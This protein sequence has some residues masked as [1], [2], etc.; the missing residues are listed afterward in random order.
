M[1]PASASRIDIYSKLKIEGFLWLSIVIFGFLGALAADRIFRRK[2]IQFSDEVKPVL[3]LPVFLEIAIAVIGT[4]F[5][6]NFLINILAGGVSYPDQKLARVTA[7]P[8][9]LQIAFAVF[10]T[11]GTC[12]FLAKILLN[13][14]A[15]W[16]AIASVLLI[17][18]SA[19]IYEKGDFLTYISSSWPATFFTKPITAVLPVQM[20]AFACLGAVWGY[21]LA[22]DYN[23]WRTHQT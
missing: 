23:W 8:A 4:V 18:Y 9:N 1:F 5:I 12:G 15:F 7:Q 11:F 21:W 16:P 19:M 14:K 10:I 13:S 2:T 22:V 6:A 17:Y 3:K 20:V